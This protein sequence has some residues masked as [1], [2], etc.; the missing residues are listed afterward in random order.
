MT[1]KD[2]EG[3]RPPR[4]R[5]G[6]PE[7]SAGS[8]E[9]AQASAVDELTRRVKT[10]KAH[11]AA[12]VAEQR[13]ADAGPIT[14]EL[15]SIDPQVLTSAD[16]GIAR[17][18]L[19]IAGIL[20]PT[21]LFDPLEQIFLKTIP[22][23][24]NHSQAK[25]ADR[26]LPLNNLIALYDAKGDS[27]RRRQMLTTML[28]MANELTDPVDAMTARIFVH[29][30]QIYEESGQPKVAAIFY[31]QL[32]RY[33]LT[34]PD[35]QA[36]T[37][38]I[39]VGKYGRVLEADGQRDAALEMYE[40][41]LAA[42]ESQ[43][44]FNDRHRLNLFVVTATA[45][46]HKGDLDK[47]ELLL[48]RARDTAERSDDKNSRVASAVYH[49]L[50]SLYLQR[51]KRERYDEAE[52]L[53]AHARDIVAETGH[54]NSS[55]YAGEIGQL[56]AVVDAKGEFERAETLYRESLR[57]YESAPDANPQDFGDFLTDAGF[58][59]MKL[60][61]PKEAVDMF[62]RARTIR[63]SIKTLH[64]LSFANTIS[65]LATA[66][67]ECGEYSDAIRLYRQAIDLRHQSPDF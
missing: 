23:L 5:K 8:A 20:L 19:E 51:G 2:G 28:A 39:L 67:F 55:E 14:A 60:R 45:L 38:L 52:R 31:R 34:S 13:P 57:I 27:Q 35:L 33:A 41:S 36:D 58:L 25:V 37:R 61:R 1:K 16:P 42:L 63:G 50:A 49:N 48:E 40:Q 6:S 15:L 46:Q 22:V 62:Q 26:F 29:M 24:W 12:L 59:Y 47:A 44:D 3:R 11:A 30:G 9:T 10:L 53:L 43:P 65:N 7:A 66:H 56:A 64:P 21:R 18:M 32:H 17:D 4:R 54:P